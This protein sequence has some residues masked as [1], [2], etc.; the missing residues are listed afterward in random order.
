MNNDCKTKVVSVKHVIR[1]R[2]SFLFRGLG[3][4]F[5]CFLF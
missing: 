5:A 3:D 2:R 1:E 4:F